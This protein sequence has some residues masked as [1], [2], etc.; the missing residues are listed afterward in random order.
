MQAATFGVWEQAVSRKVSP[1]TATD[2]LSNE[3]KNPLTAK[4]LGEKLVELSVEAQICLRTA[5]KL[6][7]E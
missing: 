2:L 7:P 5:K 1:T 3:S 6:K 4:L